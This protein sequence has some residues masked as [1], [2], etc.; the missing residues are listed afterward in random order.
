MIAAEYILLVG[1]V[2]LLLSV[3]AAKL[4][5]KFSVPALLLFLVVGMLAG[6]DGIGGIY[7]NDPP[8][9]QFISTVALIFIIFLGGL[10]TEWK[11]VRSIIAPGL[12]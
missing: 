9:A 4:A 6:S 11:D 5:E 8:A 1:S 12:S 3:T 7:F 2:L 10:V